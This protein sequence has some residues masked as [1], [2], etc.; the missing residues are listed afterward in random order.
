MIFL[1]VE[2]SDSGRSRVSEIFVTPRV[3][4]LYGAP[5]R[6]IGQLSGPVKHLSRFR[7]RKGSN[8]TNQRFFLCAQ[9]HKSILSLCDDAS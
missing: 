1:I 6:K 5:T 2:S 4:P 7:W 8:H 3:G 9:H